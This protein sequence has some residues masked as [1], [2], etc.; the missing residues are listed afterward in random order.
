MNE[1]NKEFRFAWIGAS[2]N[3]QHNTRIW[4]S[5]EGVKMCLSCVV[6]IE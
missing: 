4:I 3:C 1:E 6:V 5:P 2:K